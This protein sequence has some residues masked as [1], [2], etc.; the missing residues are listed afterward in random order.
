MTGETLAAR[1][2][3]AAASG[4]G[5]AIDPSRHDRLIRPSLPSWQ[6]HWR[7]TRNPA[8]LGPD[9]RCQAHDHDWEVDGDQFRCQRLDCKA[10]HWHVKSFGRGD[11][12][13]GKIVKKWMLTANDPLIREKAKEAMDA[14][15]ELKD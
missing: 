13:V 5:F 4:K 12:T 1:F 6:V 9:P 3:E 7:M 2:C 14:G 15:A 10:K 8:R 11:E